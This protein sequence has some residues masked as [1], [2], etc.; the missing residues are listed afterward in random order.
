MRRTDRS[1]LRHHPVTTAQPTSQ[2]D[3]A[4][5]SRRI[6][7]EGRQMQATTHPMQ[8]TTRERQET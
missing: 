2:L 6:Q 3:R 5:L 4:N 7:G 1:P 8:A